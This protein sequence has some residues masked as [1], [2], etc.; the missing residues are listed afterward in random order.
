MS[1][2]KSLVHSVNYKVKLKLNG[3]NINNVKKNMNFGSDVSLDFKV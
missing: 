1:I 2:Q 3:L